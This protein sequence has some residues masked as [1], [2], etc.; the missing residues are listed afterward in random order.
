MVVGSLFT[1]LA[2][3]GVVRMPDL[4]C[5]LSATSKAAPFG[6]GLV[7]AGTALV[8]GQTGLALQAA[9]V[10]VFVAITF[11]PSP[12]T[13][14]PAPSTGVALPGRTEI[15]R[16]A[17]S[18]FGTLAAV[19]PLV[20]LTGLTLAQPV[21]RASV[22]ESDLVARAEIDASNRRRKT[23]SSPWSPLD[24]AGVERDPGL[25][26]RTVRR[27]L[28]LEGAANLLLL[29]AKTAVG[30]ATGSLA[31]LSDALHSCP[32]RRGQQRHGSRRDAHRDPGRPIASTPTATAS[33]RPS[34][35]SDSPA[36]SP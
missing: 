22:L 29:S 21:P 34:R 32:G 31:I 7:L 6:V 23:G 1:L 19:K 24:P 5:R 16:G 18:R 12:P 36:C 11:D 4:Y 26:D 14:W 17:R 27:L 33:S 2:A 25:R 3:V 10:A 9:A 28:L 30:L 20:L 13:R 35:S 15:P 8:V